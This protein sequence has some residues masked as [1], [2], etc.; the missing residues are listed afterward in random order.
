M[1]LCG[2]SK[3]Y[4]A[5]IGG[6]T[7][8]E[9]SSLTRDDLPS[10]CG[11]SPW[12]VVYI[13]VGG[14]DVLNSDCSISTNQLK[15][16]IESAIQNV[17]NNL[18]PDA[19]KYVLTGY[20]M[21]AE[22]ED[23]SGGCSS[24]E[25]FRAIVDV[26]DA[27]SA[28]SVGLPSSSLVIENSFSVCGGSESSFSDY[29]YFQDPIHLNAKGYC[30][31]F[32]QSSIQSG[33]LCDTSESFDCDSLTGDEIYGLEDNCISGDPPEPP[34]PSPLP[35]SC[36]DTSLRFKT[37]WKGKS[38]FR[39]CDWV[40]GSKTEEKCEIEGVSELCPETCDACSNCDDSSLQFKVEWKGKTKKKRCN[41]VDRGNT[42]R[43]CNIDGVREACRSTCGE[44]D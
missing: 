42:N 21:P 30:E 7:A 40:G 11:A 37:T 38:K 17:V 36:S 27:I 13:S 16:V 19:S 14:N 6:T 34:A 10:A 41:W 3:V 12:D 29:E 43:K 25:D 33:L 18:A 24:P 35:N 9:W 20:C 15:N 8:V 28:E 23:G 26:F 39:T 31:M 2:G 1:G 32:T 44:R 5:G 22:P 4:N